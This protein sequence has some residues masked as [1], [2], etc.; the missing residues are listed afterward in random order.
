MSAPGRPPSIKRPIDPLRLE[1]LIRAGVPLHEACEY[2]GWSEPN[3]IEACLET[4]HL[5]AAVRRG[6]ATRDPGRE[7][8]G[9]RHDR[10]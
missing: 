10:P 5:K 4:P 6:H 1:A 7:Q 8:I 9:D 3:F 2:F